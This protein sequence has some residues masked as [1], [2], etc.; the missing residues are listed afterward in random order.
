MWAIIKI[1]K[2]KFFTLK[3]EFFLKLGK[4]VKFYMPK[5]KIKKYLK[6]KI[7]ITDNYLLGD[8]LLCFH[9]DLKKSSIITSLQYC[10][11]LKYFLSNFKFS[12]NEIEKF[13]NT[14]KENEDKDGYIKQTFFNFKNKDKYE[15][16]S[17]PFTNFI[18]SIFRENKFFIEAFIGKYKINVSKKDNLFRPV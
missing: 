6:S 15:F 5:I 18:F 17:G 7:F 11:G 1:D 13:I 14:C 12:Q 3:N 2:K 9:E 10:K 4:D 16:I 8:Y